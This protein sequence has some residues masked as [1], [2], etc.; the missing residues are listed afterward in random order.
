[1]WT[2]Y[3]RTVDD[4]ISVVAIIYSGDADAKALVK[5]Y[6][7]TEQYKNEYSYSFSYIG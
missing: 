5:H 1:M 4:H 3:R 6:E 2:I 7:E